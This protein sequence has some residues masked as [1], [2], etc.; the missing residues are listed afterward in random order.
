MSIVTFLFFFYYYLILFMLISCI[1]D[2]IDSIEFEIFTCLSVSYY[3]LFLCIFL[4][5]IITKYE[6]LFKIYI[7]INFL[8]KLQYNLIL[9]FHCKYSSY[10]FNFKIY[11]QA[12]ESIIRRKL[13][14]IFK[15]FINDIIE[16]LLSNSFFHFSKFYKIL[17]N[18]KTCSPIL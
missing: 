2:T 13:E 11:L 7:F 10:I 9:I 3:L 8:T 18:Y 15:Y 12:I 5:S 4:L 14:G 16:N 17:L 6:I 1:D